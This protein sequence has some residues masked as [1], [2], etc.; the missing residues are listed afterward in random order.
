MACYEFWNRGKLI[1]VVDAES[2]D[3][4]KSMLLQYLEVRKLVDVE[5]SGNVVLT[6]GE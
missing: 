1:A 4:A 3:F 5:F 2:E 6:T